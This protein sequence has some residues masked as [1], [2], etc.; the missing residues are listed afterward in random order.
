MAFLHKFQSHQNY[1]DFEVFSLDD[2][3]AAFDKIIQLKYSQN[4]SLKGKICVAFMVFNQ[5]T[6]TVSIFL[7]I[8]RDGNWCLP[9]VCTLLPIVLKS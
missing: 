7:T 1:E 2:V 4:V 9:S 8:I 6:T 5:K 3:D